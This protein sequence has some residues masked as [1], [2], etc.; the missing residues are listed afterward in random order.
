MNPPFP[1]SALRLMAWMGGDEEDPQ[2]KARFGGTAAIVL[3]LR[4]NPGLFTGVMAFCGWAIAPNGTVYEKNVT[5]YGQCV[6][7]NTGGADVLGEVRRGGMEL[8]A[9]VSID[10]HEASFADPAALVAGFAARARAEG[11]AGWNLDWEGANVTGTVDKFVRYCNLTNA[12]ADGLHAHGLA[13]SADIQWVTQPWH[14]QPNSALDAL[15]GAGRLRWS[16][17][18][19]EAPTP[20]PAADRLAHNLRLTPSHATRPTTVSMDTYYFK[21]GRVIDAMDFYTTRVPNR[22]RLGIGLS[23]REPTPTLDGFVARFHA[24]R[25]AQVRELDM[26]AMPLNETWLPWLR[27][28]KNECRGC[29]NGGAL[30]CFAQLNCF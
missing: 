9:V 24:L 25:A 30:S 7:R 26:F 19:V 23:T 12:L 15:L 28:W 2:N 5:K 14:S 3:Q 29:P 13:F 22:D 17:P 4:A 20:G 6:G 1:P 16:R 8:H 27:K 18:R 11:W 21:T 10:D